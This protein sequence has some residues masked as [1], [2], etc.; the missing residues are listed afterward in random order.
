MPDELPGC[1]LE[2][3]DSAMA[4][5][6]EEDVFGHGGGLDEGEDRAVDVTRGCNDGE[7]VGGKQVGAVETMRREDGSSSNA[8]SGK[9]GTSSIHGYLVNAS[10]DAAVR[11]MMVNS[12]PP[13]TDGATRLKD[14]QRRVRQRIAEDRGAEMEGPVTIAN[15][16]NDQQG[17]R[18][19]KE[20]SS[21]GAEPSFLGETRQLAEEDVDEVIMEANAAEDEGGSQDHIG[22]SPRHLGSSIAQPRLRRR[23]GGEGAQGP[24]R[25][26]R[27]ALSFSV[28]N[29]VANV[30]D[31]DRCNRSGMSAPCVPTALRRD[32][33]AA[34]PLRPPGGDGGG[35]SGS[36]GAERQAEESGGAQLAGDTEH[37]PKRRR[38]QEI[39][40]DS[41]REVADAVADEGYDQQHVASGGAGGAVRRRWMPEDV[42]DGG[43]RRRI[44]GKQ[45]SGGL[46]S[47]PAATY[48]FGE[49]VSGIARASGGAYQC[50]SVHG[51]TSGGPSR[52]TTLSFHRAAAEDRDGHVL[53]AGCA[54]HGAGMVERRRGRGRPPEA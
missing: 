33:P 2:E 24:V 21:G 38:L 36:S 27:L 39:G 46:S 32:S 5:E 15:V 13:S 34:E 9:R 47:A 50:N 3:A 53:T 48:V 8:R 54:Q 25:A 40:E 31:S 1:P 29:G 35:A 14:L 20:G 52:S 43:K 28:S 22:A 30:S 16:Q 18:R 11:R 17:N 4:N 26:S 7:D 51:G 44:R 37:T 45:P 41:R 19:T 49:S 6:S 12:R 23:R 10:A 42:G